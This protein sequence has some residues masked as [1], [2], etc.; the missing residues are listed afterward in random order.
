MLR[1][2]PLPNNEITINPRVISLLYYI[3]LFI[4]FIVFA[5]IRSAGIS[6]GVG[7]LE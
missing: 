3:Y 1:E 5:I 6:I 4:I 2:P 7:L